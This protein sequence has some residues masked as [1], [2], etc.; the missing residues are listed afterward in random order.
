MESDTPSRILIGSSFFRCD[1]LS[2][3]G[4]KPQG[5][6]DCCGDDPCAQPSRG[7][8]P[9]SLHVVCAIRET[10]GCRSNADDN[11]PEY[12]TTNQGD[13]PTIAA[14]HEG[15]VAD[16]GLLR[17]FRFRNKPTS[18]RAMVTDQRLPHR[19]PIGLEVEGV[20]DH[21]ADHDRAL[22]IQHGNVFTVVG[23]VRDGKRNLRSIG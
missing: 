8:L 17:E 4:S 13:A 2:V 1:I 20:G 16:E 23:V 3:T 9:H 7:H 10:D 22:Q 11:E 6:D 18:R 15:M 5:S 21:E 19:L 14:F 12:E